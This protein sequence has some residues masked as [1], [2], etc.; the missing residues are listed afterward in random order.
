[1]DPITLSAILAGVGLLKSQTID[2]AAEDRQ[3]KLRAT[4]QALSPFTGLAAQTQ[5]QEADPF[6]QSLAFGATGMSL[7]EQMQGSKQAQEAAAEQNA[8]LKTLTDAR[9][10][11]LEAEAKMIEAGIDPSTF[12]GLRGSR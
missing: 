1:M 10:K 5:V 6:G 9:A 12:S 11:K 8:I 4:E 7:G 3:R 2:K